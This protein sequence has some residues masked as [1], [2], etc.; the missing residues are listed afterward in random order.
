METNRIVAVVLL[1][2]LS[3][4][5]W[6]WG[7]LANAEPLSGSDLDSTL[8]LQC[9]LCWNPSPEESNSNRLQT[10]KSHRPRRPPDSRPRRIPKGGYKLVPDRKPSRLS[11]LRARSLRNP[12]PLST[13]QIS[14]VDGDTI[15]AGS[16]RIRLRGIDAPELSE[17]E[18]LAAKQRLE[19]LLRSGLIQIVPHGHDVYNRLI[20]DVFV[21]GQNLAETLRNEG[22]AKRF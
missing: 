14:A 5:S 4:G 13:L 21:N 18:G 9:D 15:R 20:A 16:D 8:Q 1:F 22:F 7:P 2:I 3:F 19:E 17:P 6:L 10:H 11:T 12:R